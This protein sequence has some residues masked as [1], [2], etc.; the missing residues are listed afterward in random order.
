MV[1][2]VDI[3][4]WILD[5]LARQ[6]ID[7]TT[8]TKLLNTLPILDTD[9][10]LK[11]LLILRKIE[12]EMSNGN[13]SEDVLDLLEMMEELEYRDN[14]KVGDSM[15]RAYCDVA[16]D[17]TIRALENEGL[18][19]YFELVKKIWRNRIGWMLK[20]ENVGLVSYD[21]INWR[22]DVENAVGDESVCKEVL[23]KWKGM[24]VVESVREFVRDARE[25]I[26]PSFLE[27]AC[28]D[29]RVREV[30]GFGAEV[31]EDDG[32]C[33]QTDAAKGGK[34]DE[35]GNGCDQ[36]HATKDED[37]HDQTNATEASLKERNNTVQD[38]S[39]GGAA[40]CESRGELPLPKKSVVSPVKRD[41][42]PKP[43]RRKRK[44]WSNEEEDTLRKGVK[45]YGTGN[46][47]IIL[48]MY[49][50]IFDDRTAIDLKDKWR[51]L[52]V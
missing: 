24:D 13:V 1:M 3:S 41:E 39:A 50:D 42:S 32:V 11:K 48:N 5:F 4:R 6:P 49:S 14:V 31:D 26:G 15:K 35:D 2:D 29:D 33:D 46:W 9:T 28:E 38:E 37:S 18:G 20:C 36:T 25:M 30:L 16:V 51:N 23:V 19:R 8:L 40:G 12:S 17:C 10:N 47:K 27:V 34:N 52:I 45:K 44:P 21:L 22:D 43:L 7:D